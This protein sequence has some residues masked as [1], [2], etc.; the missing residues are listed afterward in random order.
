MSTLHKVKQYFGMVP[1]EEYD[2]RYLDSATPEPRAHA[3][4]RRNLD[5]EYDGY[6]GDYRPAYHGDRGYGYG[7]REDDYDYGRGRDYGYEE[8]YEP[9]PRP[10]R[11]EPLR[12]P[13]RLDARADLHRPAPTTRGA[14]A[15]DPRV[16]QAADVS[17]L[18]RIVTLKPSAYE[19]A[20]TIGEKYREGT[21]VV[22]D[23]TAMENADAKRLVDFA[24]GLAFALRGSFDRLAPKVFILSTA[25]IDV[26]AEERA[27]IAES[28]F[29]TN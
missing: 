26:T 18:S 12:S 13:E 17:A 11:L 25:D 29:Y 4:R 21:P 8:A 19:D 27:R 10:A 22:M 6:E 2:D 7:G 15:V 1:L 5:D 16:E 23:L 14:L 20:R 9:A 28:G 3:A 24:A